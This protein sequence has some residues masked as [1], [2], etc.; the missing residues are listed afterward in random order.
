VPL[1]VVTL[2]PATA[3]SPDLHADAHDI[4]GPVPPSIVSFALMWR[5]ISSRI[6]RGWRA[7]RAAGAMNALGRHHLRSR[8][9]RRGHRCGA[10]TQGGEGRLGQDGYLARRSWASPL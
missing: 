1:A 8:G 4:A 2:R 7:D 9:L 6:R 10:V 5:L 3:G